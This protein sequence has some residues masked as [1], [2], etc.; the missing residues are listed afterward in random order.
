M[1]GDEIFIDAIFND[2]MIETIQ[3]Y[4]DNLSLDDSSISGFIKMR[5]IY[6]KLS[7]NEKIILLDYFRVIT[8]NSVST[9]LGLVDGTSFMQGIDED[10]KLFYGDEEIQGDLQ[11]LFIGK[12]QDEGLV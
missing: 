12:P 9:I 10:L 1:K 6:S 3:Q 5:S 7:E 8:F 2:L 4:K 11:D